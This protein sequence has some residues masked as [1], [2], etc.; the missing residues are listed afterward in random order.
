MVDTFGLGSE[1]RDDEYAQGPMS[2]EYLRNAIALIERSGI[3]DKI[4][5]WEREKPA[6]QWLDANASSP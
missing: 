1:E 5:Q 3:N 2:L 4:V 6:R